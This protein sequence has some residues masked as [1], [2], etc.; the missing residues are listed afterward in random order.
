MIEKYP[1]RETF[2][3]YYSSF[4]GG[5]VFRLL[6]AKKYNIIAK[7]VPILKRTPIILD[8]GCGA[9]GISSQLIEN[10]P[11]AKI[12]GL[13]IDTC[14]LRISRARGLMSV[15]GS[16]NNTLP[17]PDDKFDGVLMIDAIEHVDNRNQSLEEIVRILKKDGILILFTPPYNS[18]SWVLG[19]LLFKLVTRRRT[20][21]ISPFTEESL[22]WLLSRYFEEWSVLSTNFGLTL[23]GIGRDKL[24]G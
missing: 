24:V 23:C 8:I 11:D 19:E 4:L 5:R 22:S 21:H 15:G 2:T 12:I 14:L 18:L 1:D 17:F 10:K 16:F 13:D 20:D 9:G 6:D 3:D 7:T